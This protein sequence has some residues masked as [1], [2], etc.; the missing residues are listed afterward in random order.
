MIRRKK[1]SI[2]FFAAVT[3][4]KVLRSCRW[5]A[6]TMAVSIGTWA[7]MKVWQ[8]RQNDSN[9]Y[10]V[11]TYTKT[12]QRMPHHTNY[13][14]VSS[15]DMQ[16]NYKLYQNTPHSSQVTCSS[17]RCR[18]CMFCSFTV[19]RSLMQFSCHNLKRVFLLSLI[20]QQYYWNMYHAIPFHWGNACSSALG[21]DHQ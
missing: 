13:V 17:S 16:T 14:L 6:E 20:N 7:K 9:G 1:Y 5:D 10:S 11:H 3:I 21:S 12:W 15:K 4:T 19:C 2:F 18:N 8:K